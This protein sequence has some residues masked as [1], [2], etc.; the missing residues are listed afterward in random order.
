LSSIIPGAGDDFSDFLPTFFSLYPDYKPNQ[1]MHDFAIANY[2]YYH[3][4]LWRREVLP[5]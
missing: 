5:A 2:E 4:G 1:G 3:A